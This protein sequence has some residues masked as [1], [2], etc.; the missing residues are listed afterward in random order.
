[1]VIRG[2]SELIVAFRQAR[3]ARKSPLSDITFT[4]RP[5]EPSSHN[6]LMPLGFS[7]GPGMARAAHYPSRLSRGCIP[8]QTPI[9]NRPRF[10]DTG[11]A[12]RGRGIAP[13]ASA[14]LCS[15]GRWRHR[16][17]R[18]S[19]LRSYLRARQPCI[20]PQPP[21]RAPAPLAAALSA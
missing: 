15:F 17:R 1:M 14:F 2:P 21:D 4:I 7:I 20:G 9:T 3:P 18:L 13:A 6:S 10:I 8:I 12:G 16:R 19:L 5:A 11:R